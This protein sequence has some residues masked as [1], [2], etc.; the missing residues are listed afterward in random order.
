M[1]TFLKSNKI[2]HAFPALCEAGR[3]ECSRLLSRSPASSDILPRDDRGV[4][5]YSQPSLNWGNQTGSRKPVQAFKT[6]FDGTLHHAGLHSLQNSIIFPLA[7][8]SSA[9]MSS[10]LLMRQHLFLVFLCIQ[11]YPKWNHL[12]LEKYSGN[13]MLRL[14]S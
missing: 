7:A 8:L 1:S 2:E 14:K 12:H 5:L 9:P 6:F 13:Y 10:S 4:S 3:E 11:K